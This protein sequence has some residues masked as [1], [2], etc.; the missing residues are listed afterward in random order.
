MSGTSQ[1]CEAVRMS[2]DHVFPASFLGGHENV[3]KSHSTGNREARVP[4]PVLGPGQGFF[5]LWNSELTCTGRG[6]LRG[7]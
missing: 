4:A 1:G 5:L 7:M 2:P 6:L 3:W